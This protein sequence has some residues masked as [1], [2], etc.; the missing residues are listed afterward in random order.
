MTENITEIKPADKL[1][2]EM[3]DAPTP[4]VEAPEE[5]KRSL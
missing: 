2:E 3:L 5:P 4:K 1:A